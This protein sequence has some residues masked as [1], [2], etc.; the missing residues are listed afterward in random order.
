MPYTR[1]EHISG[2]EQCRIDLGTTTSFAAASALL[3]AQFN[4]VCTDPNITQEQLER[5]TSANILPDLSMLYYLRWCGVAQEDIMYMKWKPYAAREFID[6][7]RAQKVSCRWPK[8]NGI[9]LSY[10]W[11]QSAPKIDMGEA[12]RVGM[13]AANP[14]RGEPYPKLTQPQQC[15][16]YVQAVQIAGSADAANIAQNTCGL[17]NDVCVRARHHVCRG[18]GASHATDGPRDGSTLYTQCIRDNNLRGKT[19]GK[20]SGQP[21]AN[22]YWT[23]LEID[24]SI[25]FH[26][27]KLSTETDSKVCA[28]V[29]QRMSVAA[30]HTSPATI[31]TCGED[32]VSPV[33]SGSAMAAP[34]TASSVVKRP[35]ESATEEQ[36]DTRSDEADAS[37]KRARVNN[38]ATA[39]TADAPCV[40]PQKKPGLAEYK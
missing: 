18:C 15:R 19:S 35:R 12:V 32:T 30:S 39:A 4:S 24:R 21:P 16:N 9:S 8:D 6:L 3:A 37:S 25:N 7:L 31:V 22:F 36:A 34:A 40:P 10:E 28:S 33:M 23:D 29:A 5:L 20:L 11:E 1:I 14:S 26:A 27:P 13:R 38:T 2:L 17:S